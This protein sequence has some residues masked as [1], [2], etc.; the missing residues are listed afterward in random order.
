MPRERRSKYANDAKD[1][2]GIAS[3]VES[4]SSSLAQSANQIRDNTKSIYTTSRG[5]WQPRPIVTFIDDDGFDNLLN[6]L[7]P[8]FLEKN[9]P[10]VAAVYSTSQVLN[11]TDKINQLLDLQNNHGWEIASHTM[12]HD[13]LAAMNEQQIRD[14]SSNIL[15][16]LRNLKFNVESIVYPFGDTTIDSRRVISE[17]YRCGVSVE[18]SSP[19]LKYNLFS[20]PNLYNLLRANIGVDNTKDFA[21]YKQIVDDA[22]AN[23]AWLIWEMHINM[24]SFDANQRIILGQIIDYI[25]GLNIQIVN[26]RDGLNYYEPL[27]TSDD[28]SKGLNDDYFTLHKTGKVISNSAIRYEKLN[29]H[30]STDL[31]S[32]YVNPLTIFSVNSSGNAGYP[33]S[34]TVVTIKGNDKGWHN[35]LWFDYY[36]NAMQIRRVDSAGVWTTWTKLI[37]QG[38]LDTQMKVKFFSQNAFTATTVLTD[39]TNDQITVFP[40]NIAGGTGFPNNNA[41]I[42]TTYRLNGNGFSRQEFREYLSS[43]LYTRYVNGSGAWTAWEQTSARSAE[44]HAVNKTMNAYTNASLLTDFPLNTLTTFFFD[45]SNAGFPTSAGIVTTYRMNVNA[46][47]KQECRQYQGNSVWSRYWDTTNTVWT[48]WIKISAV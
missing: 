31:I 13:H 10:L 29:A 32:A 15:N 45:S 30:P 16:Y 17:Y 34:G 46:W 21:Y 43:A 2:V 5:N 24:A 48:A 33:G 12:Y 20:Q 36:N 8:I 6:V 47:G 35:Q 41:G 23:N 28:Y 26:I 22:V 3:Q 25:K 11:T 42:V 38:D 44:Y 14:D 40:V 18:Q 1:T 19:T 9:V 4:L 7:K 37:L 39:F 27:V